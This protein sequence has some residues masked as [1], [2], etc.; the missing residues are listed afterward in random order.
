MGDLDYEQL[1]PLFA[2]GKN[3]DLLPLLLLLLGRDGDTT[4]SDDDTD[5]APPNTF[6]GYL[7]SLIGDEVQVSLGTPVDNGTLLNGRLTDVTAEYIILR[8]VWASG[9]FLGPRSHVAV[10][11]S[12]IVGINRLPKHHQWLPLLE[13]CQRR[14]G[15]ES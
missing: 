8:N 13:L 10:L 2:S 14:S 11:I 15:S 7:M 12:N 3:K 4:T 5:D 1:M 6:G 9:V